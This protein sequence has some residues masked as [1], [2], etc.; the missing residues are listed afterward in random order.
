MLYEYV[1]QA[2]NLNVQLRQ[3]ELSISTT[4]NG[5]TVIVLAEHDNIDA[6]L[7]HEL[8]H[9]KLKILGYRQ[10]CSAYAKEGRERLNRILPMLDN[11]LQ[12]HRFFAEFVSLGFRPEEMYGESE[13]DWEVAV[14][15]LIDG[16]MGMLSIDQ[17][18]SPYITLIAPGGFGSEGERRRVI[19]RLRDRCDVGV[20]KK[21]RE[22]RAAISEFRD[23]S[24]LDA[25]LTIARILRILG[26]F[27]QAWV[28][29]SAR[30]PGD[31]IYVRDRFDLS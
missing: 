23:G 1:K 28:G 16:T 2:T 31:G 9:A 10:Y 25:G 4:E 20:Y 7:A 14:N 19:D 27:S 17:A 3:E 26:G 24:S 11:E 5:L 6:A 21:L 18:L 22:I 12:H 15:E 30:F 8:L 29:Y 13:G